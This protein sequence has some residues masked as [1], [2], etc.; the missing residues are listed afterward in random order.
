VANPPKIAFC[1]TCKG[2]TQHLKMTLPK[3]LADNADYPN[4]RFIVLDYASPDDLRDYLASIRAMITVPDMLVVYSFPEAGS[5]RMAHAKN[6]AHR[7]GLLEGADIL[8]NLDA[9]NYTG[10]GFAEYIAQLYQK[11]GT[12]IY[13]WSRMVKEG[14]D[15]LGR[16]IS[17]RIVVTCQAFLKTGG[18]DEKFHTWSPDDKDFNARLSRLGYS[19]Y[20]I[21]PK[22]LNVV[23]HNDKMRFREY[24][25]AKTASDSD[26]FDLSTDTHVLANYGKFGCGTVYRNFSTQTIELKPLPTRIFG[27]GLHKTATTSLHKALTILGFDSAHWKT[28]HWAKHIWREMTTQGRS[29]TLEKHYALSDLPIPLLYKQLDGVYGGSKFILTVRD[30]IKWLRSVRNHWDPRHNRFRS[31]WDSDPFTHQVHRLL[32]GQKNFDVEVFR[33][34]YRRHNSEVQA[35]F[36]HRP[37]DLLVM[38]MDDDSSSK[39]WSLCNFLGCEVPNVPYPMEF[40]TAQEMTGGEGI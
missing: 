37:Q 31:A 24:P 33:A 14:Q 40:A 38:N 22:F 26:S 36:K 35:Y 29:L 5:F 6:M 28:A 2:R 19:G 21:D 39:W 7:C 4:C 34:R 13:L 30:E 18:Y 16:G 27:I 15:R 12:D 20:E 10:H 3:N 11:H 23:L 17:G 32:Y 8:V 9:D 1:T 25:H